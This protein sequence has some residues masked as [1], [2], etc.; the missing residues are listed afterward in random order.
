MFLFGS[1]ELRIMWPAG[2]SKMAGIIQDSSALGILGDRKAVQDSSALGILRDQEETQLYVGQAPGKFEVHTPAGQE[3]QIAAP[4]ADA[5]KET[6]VSCLWNCADRRG[7]FQ[8]RRRH[9]LA[10]LSV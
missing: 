7:L 5:S 3:F 1:S 10:I 8:L 4:G 6:A 9:W 2:S